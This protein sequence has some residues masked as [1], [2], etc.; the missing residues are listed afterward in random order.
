MGFP[1]VVRNGRIVTAPHFVTKNGPGTEIVP[2]LLA[3]WTGFDAASVIGDRLSLPTRI[4]NDADLQGLAVIAGNGLE[5]VITLGTGV[6]T[7]MFQNGVL[8]PHLELAHHPFRKGQTYEEQLGDAALHRVGEKKW[9]RRVQRAIEAIRH[10]TNFDTLFIGGGN[11][12]HIEFD[13]PNDVERISNDDGMLGG[14]WLWRSD[15]QHL[16]ASS[17]RVREGA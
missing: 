5:L 1:G 13:L 10:L 14:I 11:A 17:S 12:R 9:N 8:A 4:L 3:A 2:A 16:M 7:A 15:R 6:G